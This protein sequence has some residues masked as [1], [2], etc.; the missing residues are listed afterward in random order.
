MGEG[1]AVVRLDIGSGGR[2]ERGADWLGVD[3]YVPT[4]DV[5]AEMGDLPFETESV[6]EI[7][8]AHALEHVAIR[9]VLPTLQ[10]WFRVLRP[11]GRLTLQVPD[12]AWCLIQWLAHP[13][14]GFELMRIFG[15]QEHDGEYH[16]CGFT[17]QILAE[18]L[19]TV[20]FAV[21]KIDT[22]WSHAQ[23]TLSVE[24]VKPEGVR[25]ET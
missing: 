24:A 17:P 8:S 21:R 3:A 9:Q 12:L 5:Q 23:Q 4:A 16:R 6:E 7:F 20:G 25:R 1:V 15:N 10:E 18:Q 13:T 22:I 11:G 19:T 2:S 14:T